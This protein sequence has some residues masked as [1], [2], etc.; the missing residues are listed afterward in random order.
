MT[1]NSYYLGCRPKFCFFFFF[2][3]SIESNILTRNF[4]SNIISYS[5]PVIPSK[6]MGINI[7]GREEKYSTVLSHLCRLVS[8]TFYMTGATCLLASSKREVEKAGFPS[9]ITEPGM[10][11]Q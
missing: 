11:V 8:V 1:L 5:I 6:D 3:N 2:V 9:Q 4:V 7:Y 10:E